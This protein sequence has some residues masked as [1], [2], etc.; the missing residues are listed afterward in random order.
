L[1]AG[2]PLSAGNTKDTTGM[3]K[4]DYRL[5]DKRERAP[6]EW[7]DRGWKSHNSSAVFKRLV[8]QTME[9]LTHAPGN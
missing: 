4:V 9:T 7:A 8:R 2:T 3:G 6:N 1:I 5:A